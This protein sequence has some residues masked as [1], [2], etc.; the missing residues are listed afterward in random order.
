[1][2]DTYLGLGKGVIKFS[3]GNFNFEVLTE[4]NEV[5]DFIAQEVE[6]LETF[7]NVRFYWNTLEEEEMTDEELK[8]F[9]ENNSKILD[10]LYS[11]YTVG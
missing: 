6:P 10:L 1:M 11:I 9:S 2:N 3:L 7:S 5:V 8:I 4:N